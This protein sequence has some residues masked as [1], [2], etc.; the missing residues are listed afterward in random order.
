ML[1][2]SRQADFASAC[3]VFCIYL[4]VNYS[5]SFAENDR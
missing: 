2:L 4:S 5:K 1:H 3:T